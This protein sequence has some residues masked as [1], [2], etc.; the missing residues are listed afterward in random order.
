MG[1]YVGMSMEI[2]DDGYVNVG[3]NAYVNADVM[4]IMLRVGVWV[5]ML[6]IIGI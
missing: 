1:A 2:D 4:M 3:M 6:M 5:C